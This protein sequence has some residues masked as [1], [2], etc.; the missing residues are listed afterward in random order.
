MVTKFL[1][2]ID[3]RAPQGVRLFCVLIVTV[4]VG[5]LQDGKIRGNLRSESEVEVNRFEGHGDLGLLS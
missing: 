4:K 2:P 1:V 5:S 3:R